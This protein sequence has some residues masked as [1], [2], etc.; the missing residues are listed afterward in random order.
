M[1]SPIIRFKS[2]NISDVTSTWIPRELSSITYRVTRKNTD[3]QTN[4]PLTL[5]A[6]YGLIAQDSYFKKTVASTDLSKYILL[7]KGEFAYN[8][9]SSIGFEYGAIK[10]LEAHSCGAVTP[11]YFC[12]G[13]N[14]NANIDSDF[15]AYYFESQKWNREIAAYC[16]EGAR[17]HGALNVSKD[18]FFAINVYMPALNEQRKIA[19]LLST[20]DDVITKQ[21]A[22]IDAWEL[23]KKGVAQRLF[24]QEV[25]FKADDGS[26]FPAWKTLSF[27]KV[28]SRVTNNSLSWAKLIR[29]SDSSTHHPKN[30]HYGD[31][32]TRFG[33]VLDL[34]KDQ[35]PV[36]KDDV[37]CSRLQP[38]QEGDVVF[39][40]AAED[41]TVGKAIEVYN[42]GANVLYA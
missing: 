4:L 3:N 41:D 10:R 30:I 35:V 33:E 25:R 6:R 1:A 16:A 32:H 14:N 36:I 13:I 23:R 34:A 26:I 15:L 42:L 5:S 9:S 8:H 37:D 17:Q 40:D 28:F 22:E 18:D 31:I 19:D 2:N 12:F 38:L 24:S 7:H 21:E 11:V 39:A 20:V 27:S 29:E